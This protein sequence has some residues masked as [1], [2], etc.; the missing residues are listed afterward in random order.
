MDVQGTCAE[1]FEPVR[2]AFAAN[3][4][5][6]GEIGAAVSVVRGGQTVVDLW[7]G[8]A[9]AHTDRAWE[10][11][12]PVLVYSTTKGPTAVCAL[13]LWERGL[14]DIDAP[15]AD[16]W[17]EF[18]A[19]GKGAVTTR[20]LLTHQAGLP[21]FD[22]PITFT[23]CHDADLVAARLAA[24]TPRW[25]PGTAHGYHP[26]TFGWLVG[27]VVRRVSGR[28]VGTMLAE[29]VTVPLGLDLWIGL[30]PEREA[31]VARLAP[32]RFDLAGMRPDDPGLIFAAAI[33]DIE[34]LTFRAFSNPPGQF[35][36]ESFNAPELHQAEWPA[37]NGIAT[38]PALARMY[39][40]LA[41]DRILSSTTLDEASR[42]QVRRPRPGSRRR[43]RLRARLLPGVGDDGPRP[44]ELRPRGRRRLG[45]FRRS[46]L[47]PGLRLRD[48]PADG[49][50]GRRP[51]VA[52]AGGG[53]LL[54]FC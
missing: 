41:E 53:R 13:L 25:E 24:Q 49:V 14:L 1:G 54:L 6:P 29:E 7:G 23:E 42:Q 51:P 19:A 9:D 3:F 5:D 26:L 52:P 35:D 30:P 33:L 43:H 46:G 28:S 18:A 34:S 45:G 37:A 40:E 8:L 20:H 48:E 15:V 38:A 36:V 10:R 47:R 4:V 12:T 31:S 16:V 21:V 11:D 22:E 39:G 2:D 50:A 44:G 32:G 17:P 27:E